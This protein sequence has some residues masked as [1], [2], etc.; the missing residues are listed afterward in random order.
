MSNIITNA[1]EVINFCRKRMTKSYIDDI[2]GRQY[3][4]GRYVI[5][6]NNFICPVRSESTSKQPLRYLYIISN[7]LRLS[8]YL[9]SPTEIIGAQRLPKIVE[10]Y[11]S[12]IDLYPTMG[13]KGH[14]QLKIVNSGDSFAK[15][16]SFH[17]LNLK[18]KI[19]ALLDMGDR[20]CMKYENHNRVYFPID[21]YLI[22]NNGMYCPFYHNQT[23]DLHPLDVVSYNSIKLKVVA[24]KFMGRFIYNPTDTLEE[25]IHSFNLGVY[26]EAL[27]K[28]NSK[29]GYRAFNRIPNL[30]TQIETMDFT[31]E[32]LSFLYKLG[33]RLKYVTGID[34][35]D[36][37][38]AL[39]NGQSV[40]GR[41]DILRHLREQQSI[42]ESSGDIVEKIKRMNVEEFSKTDD[43]ALMGLIGNPVTIIGYKDYSKKN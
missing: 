36:K 4:V 35:R 24:K 33:Y 13:L 12:A 42:I 7:K 17:K 41:E 18:D 16:T 21:G 11:N 31:A 26:N 34:F 10:E 28:L 5:L 2:T 20:Q 38:R 43:I 6:K 25:A 19:D 15:V 9:A 32:K 1:D 3:N 14:S 29:Y 30:I 23:M 22:L 39:H 8:A 27:V 40:F 37:L